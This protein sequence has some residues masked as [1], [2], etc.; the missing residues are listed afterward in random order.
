MKLTKEQEAKLIQMAF[1]EKSNKEIAKE[2][3]IELNDVHAARSRLGITI[4]KVKAL[5]K[6]GAKP[7]SGRTEKEIN[8]EINKVQKARTEAFNKVKRCTDRLDELYKE[9][10]GC[11]KVLKY[12]SAFKQN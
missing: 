7:Y 8:E 9:L 2:L 11:N 6:N 3:D 5:K 10:E 1:D 4:P 12:A